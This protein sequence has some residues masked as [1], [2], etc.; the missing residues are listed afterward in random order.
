MRQML[1]YRVRYFTDG[2]ALG[3][4]EFME[5]VFR[6]YRG[7]FGEKRREGA[8]ALRHGDWGGLCVLRD[9]RVEVISS[10]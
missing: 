2:L 9:L 1:R 10:A 7:Q 3:S 6:R 8:R 5:T 4:R